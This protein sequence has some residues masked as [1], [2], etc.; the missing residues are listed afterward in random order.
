MVCDE[1]TPFFHALMTMIHGTDDLINKTFALKFCLM[2]ALTSLLLPIT[3]TTLNS[4]WPFLTKLLLQPLENAISIL[5]S[6][7]RTLQSS[8]ETFLQAG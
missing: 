2:H 7:G 1:F 3:I 4:L 8:S 5:T 6:L